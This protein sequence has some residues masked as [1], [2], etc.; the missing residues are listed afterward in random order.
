MASDMLPTAVR[1]KAESKR[2]F[3]GRRKRIVRYDVRFADGRVALDVDIDRA[4]LGRSLP[5]DAWATKAAAEAECPEVGVG[6]WVEYA[7]GR[8]RHA[9]SSVRTCLR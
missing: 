5:A 3:F 6:A 4:L 8:R 2:S 9:L 1:A 7:Y